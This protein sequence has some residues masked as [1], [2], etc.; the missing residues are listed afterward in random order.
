[1]NLSDAKTWALFVLDKRNDNRCMVFGMEASS[2]SLPSLQISIEDVS[3]V[4][5]NHG[6]AFWIKSDG[7][8]MSESLY[9]DELLKAMWLS[10]SFALPAGLTGWTVSS[11]STGFQWNCVYRANSQ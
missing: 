6:L 5:E 10:R 4:R 2:V 9:P 3:C 11:L 7:T 8:I 1:M